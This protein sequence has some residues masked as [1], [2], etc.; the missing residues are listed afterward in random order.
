M[1]EVRVISLNVNGINAADK[2]RSM[3]SKLREGGYDLCLLQECHSMQTTAHLWQSEW[4]GQ[5]LFSHGASNSRGVAILLRRD[6]EGL[7]QQVVRDDLGRIL[8]LQVQIGGMT[9]ILGSVYAPTADRQEDQLQ[10]L[11]VLESKPDMLD[12]TNLILGGDLNIALDPNLDRKGVRTQPQG[13]QFRLRVIHFMDEQDLGDGWRIQNPQKRGYSFHRGQQASRIDYFLLSHHLLDFSKRLNIIPTALSDHSILTLTLEGKCNP[14]GPGLWRFDTTLLNNEQYVLQ[15]IELLSDLSRQSCN[16]EPEAHWEWTKYEIRKFTRTFE[17]RLREEHRKKEKELNKLLTSLTER[18]DNGES[19]LEERLLATRDTLAELELVR[20]QRIIFRSRYNWSQYGERS[21]RYFLNLEKRK[22]QN[23]VVSALRDDR[24]RLITDS[25]EILKYEHDFYQSLYSGDPSAQPIPMEPPFRDPPQISRHHKEALERPLSG[26]ELK[27]ALTQLNRGKCPGTDGLSVDFYLRFWSLI[28]DPLLKCL[29]SANASGRLT[30]EQRRGIINLIP[31]KDADRS[32][33]SNWRP[34]TLLNTDYKIFTKALA[35]R[36]Q[37]CVKEVISP[38]QTGFLPG[39]YIGTNIR[40]ITDAMQEL[41]RSE[42]GGWVFSCDFRKAFDTV[43]WDLIARALEWF[44]F[45]ERFRDMVGLLFVEPE[46]A[47]LNNGFS[48]AYFRPS[49]GVRQGCCLSPYLFIMAAET[50]ALQIRQNESIRGVKLGTIE[51]KTT[52]FADDLTCF[53][54]DRASLERLIALIGD[55]EKDSGLS[56]NLNKSKI[57]PAKKEQTTDDS[58]SGIEVTHQFQTLGVWFT[59]QQSP[60][61]DYD[62]NF[63]PILSKMRT[64]CESWAHRSLS[65]KGKITVINTLITSRLQYI[66]SM[67]YTPTRVLDEVRK[68]ITQF[69]W[70]GRRSKIAYATLIQLTQNGGL[71]LADLE[72]RIKVIMLRWISRLAMDPGAFPAV[73]L[74]RLAQSDD[75]FNIFLAKSRKIPAGIKENPF[76][77]AMFGIWQDHHRFEPVDEIEVRREG[78]WRNRYITDGKGDSLC[79]KKWEKANIITIHDICH[80]TEDRLLSHTE[81]QERYS[82]PCTFLDMLTLRLGIPLH[83]RNMITP[84]FQGNIDQDLY[85]KFHTGNTLSVI[86]TGPKAL[87][88]EIING[89]RSQP[90]AKKKWEATVNIPSNDEWKDHY[91]RA[92]RT[93][94]ETKYQSFQCRLLH[95]VITC[96]HLL[97]RWKMREDGLCDVCDREDTIEHFFYNCPSSRNFWSQVKTWVLGAIQVSLAGLTIKEFLLGVPSVFPQAHIVNYLLLHGRFFIHRQR[98][99]HDSNLSLSHWIRELRSRLLTERAICERGGNGG[100]FRKWEPLLAVTENVD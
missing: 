59:N 51:L 28:E 64:C 13:E 70:S 12:T 35:L 47:I 53:T 45:G 95:R 78:I 37:S 85:A 97:F 65:I 61:F 44:G 27:T 63:K 92:F 81:I 73:F 11:E 88:T 80:L 16:A 22:T 98:L 2:R 7:V 52:L 86:K 1:N 55:Y 68:M 100:K 42:D 38:D 83:W 10:F 39:R 33:L 24:G 75:L 6:F 32:N 66:C 17:K 77:G 15:M 48:S 14:K 34:I 25:K 31:K 89:M 58:I 9:Y 91:T 84:N 76:Y 19:G 40:T 93:T 49:R 62:R 56:I 50:L 60:S 41:Q 71:K 36:V 82:V 5:V 54:K 43:S 30:T 26:V 72:T 57:T 74:G 21:S 8:L 46:T 23:K 18:Q 99:F 90:T 67:I 87:Y 29:E 20:A 79:W 69:I 94:R 96:N 3:F 4:G